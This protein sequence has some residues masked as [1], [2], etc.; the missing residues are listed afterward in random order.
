MSG[1][2]IYSTPSVPMIGGLA[3]HENRY[4]HTWHPNIAV[5]QQGSQRH[6]E[7]LTRIKRD[8]EE[9]RLEPIIQD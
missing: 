5:L 1:L 4:Q 2:S 6:L 8:P 3:D 9:E 7:A